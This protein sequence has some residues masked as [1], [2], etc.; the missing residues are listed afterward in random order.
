MVAFENVTENEP[1]GHMLARI[2]SGGRPVAL[3]DGIAK[4]LNCLLSYGLGLETRLVLLKSSDRKFQH[5][6]SEARVGG[7]WKF[8]DPT[9]GF[10]Y[11]KS[12]R[13]LCSASELGSAVTAESVSDWNQRVLPFR[14]ITDSQAGNY[15]RLFEEVTYG[16]HI[17]GRESH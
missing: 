8:L 6:V 10:Y 9:N 7:S 15:V 1:P 12:G 3:C 14:S 11:F 4:M 5:I 2:E 17:S 16:A 13:Q